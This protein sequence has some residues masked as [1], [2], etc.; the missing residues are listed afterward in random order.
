[1]SRSRNLSTRPVGRRCRLR[2]A[3]LAEKDRSGDAIA[4]GMDVTGRW[5][6]WA[7]H[8]LEISQRRRQ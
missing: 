3:L 7:K 8:R 1:M 5:M 6:L 2:R 4:V